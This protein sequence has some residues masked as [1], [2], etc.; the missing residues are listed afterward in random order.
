MR[1][2]RFD[3]VLPLCREPT[4]Q[5]SQ[6]TIAARITARI[7]SVDT[8]VLSANFSGGPY[9]ADLCRDLPSDVDPC[10]ERGEFRTFAS[11]GPRF[12]APVGYR[13][14]EVV[15]REARFASC[16]LIPEVVSPIATLPQ[17]SSPRDIG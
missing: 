12:E 13:V 5:L 15:L 3:Y 14:G 2:L 1:R 8:N 10:G 4:T 6:A 9:D 11:D 16:D 17:T 7:V